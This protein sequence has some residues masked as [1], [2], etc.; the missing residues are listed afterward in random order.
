MLILN[1]KLIKEI[2]EY[3][4]L[5]NISD[6]SNEV[7]NM[8]RCGFNI[9]KFGTSPFNKPNEIIKEKEVVENIEIVEEKTVEKTPIETKPKK[10]IRVIKNK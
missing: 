4:I 2:E 9:T 3:C 5:N 7:N 10:R 6:T 8:L 1:E